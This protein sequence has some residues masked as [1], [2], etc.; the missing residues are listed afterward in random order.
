MSVIDDIKARVDIVDLVGETVPLK[1]TGRSFKAPCPF[2]IEKTPSFVV[3]PDR[4]SWHCFGACGVGGDIFGFVQKRDNVEFAAALRTLAKRASVDLAPRDAAREERFERLYAAN[5][6][7]ATFYHSRL[8]QADDAAEARAYLERRG[9]D[10]ATTRDFR[11][12]YAPDAWD[13]LRTHLER[14]GFTTAELLAAGLLVESDR[15]GYDRFRARVIFPINDERG[16]VVGF[17]GRE[18]GNEG[19]KYL[20]TAQ[21]DIFDKSGV[22]YTLDRAK[23]RIR[24]ENSAVIVEGYMDAI[25]AHQ[26]GYTNVVA[27]M[28]AALTERQVDLLKRHT[29]NLVLALDADAAGSE[30]TLRGIQVVVDAADYELTAVPDWRGLIRYQDTLAADIRVV[31]LSPGKDPDDTIRERPEAWPELIA[32]ARPVLDHLLTVA[33]ERFDLTQPR[34]RSRAVDSLLPALAAVTDPLLRSHYLQRLATLARV[35]EATLLTRIRMAGRPQQRRAPQNAAGDSARPAL[36]EGRARNTDAPPAWML[37]DR[38]EEFLLAMLKRHPSLEPRGRALPADSFRLAENRALFQC[39]LA[40]TEPEPGAPAAQRAEQLATVELPPYDAASA[41]AAFGGAL[42]LLHRERLLELKR[43]TQ[44][45]VVENQEM[46]GSDQD[47]LIEHALAEREGREDEGA[48]PD[49]AS[50][51]LKDID[52]GLRLHGRPVAPLPATR[53]TPPPTIDSRQ[54]SAG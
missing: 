10:E 8:L 24:T 51:I 50:T 47:S 16:R 14:R 26:F 15:G 36:V 18:L 40:G 2:H 48:G 3:S 46:E 53:P 52:T 7:A 49:P 32:T 34:E 6:A 5:D 13:A 38:R 25:A 42:R 19:P 33:R 39:W 29:R 27:S 21:T 22:V 35:E 17:G 44:S 11:I 54:E 45:T 43:L 30:A 28:G 4:Q 23:E 31:A 41:D 9:L 1:K 20:N 37:R 12:G